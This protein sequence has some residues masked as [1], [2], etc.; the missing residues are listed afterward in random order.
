[1]EVQ[2]ELAVLQLTA[3]SLQQSIVLTR[4]LGG[5]YQAEGDMR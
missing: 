4:T 1:M 2:E 3:Q 5:G